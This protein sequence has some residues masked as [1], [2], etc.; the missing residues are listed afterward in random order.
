MGKV[1]Q[2]ATADARISIT[3]LVGARAGVCDISRTN[4][5][6]PPSGHGAKADATSNRRPHAH[7]SPLLFAGVLNHYASLKR[8]QLHKGIDNK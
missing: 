5:V 8:Q 6:V 2:Q 1:N 7:V 4:Q 3:T